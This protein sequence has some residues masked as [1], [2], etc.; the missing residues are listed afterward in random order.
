VAKDLARAVAL[1]AK[2]CDGG[3]PLGCSNL[4]V[5]VRRGDGVAR[6]LTWATALTTKACDGG[7]ADGCHSL[8]EELLEQAK[9]ATGRE[10]GRLFAAA[11]EKCL[12]A[13]RLERGTGAYNL[14]CIAA[15]HRDG[16]ECR[17]WLEES[18]AQGRLP[19]AEHL[20]K[21]PDLDPVRAEAWFK[22]FLARVTAANGGP[23]PPPAPPPRR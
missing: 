7:I 20:T 8:C 16:A 6:D 17:R 19:S 1:F 5:M 21:D 10:A 2:A 23:A 4:G 3:L 22:V 11:R 14:A 12:A 13:N 9:A 18:R 15:L